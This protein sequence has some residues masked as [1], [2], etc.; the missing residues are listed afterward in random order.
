MIGAKLLIPKTLAKREF[1]KMANAQNEV[2]AAWRKAIFT[3]L[4]AKGYAGCRLLKAYVTTTDGPRRM[5]FLLQNSSGDSFFLM[6]RPKGDAVGDNMSYRNPRFAKVLQRAM[7]TA[8][9]DIEA[10]LFSLIER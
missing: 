3:S 4:P 8:L 1:G 2:V 9:A 7:E 6:H 10:G 5:L